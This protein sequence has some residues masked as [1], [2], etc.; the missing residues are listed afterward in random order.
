MSDRE[1]A[2]A[3]HAIC[4]QD[5]FLAIK[6]PQC[7]VKAFDA[8]LLRSRRS[9]LTFRTRSRIYDDAISSAMQRGAAR[10][11]ARSVNNASTISSR[12][13]ARGRTEDINHDLH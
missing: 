6:K 4:L 8:L 7:A 10:A 9:V 3:H 13:L 5:I 2:S 12:R 1:R 11:R